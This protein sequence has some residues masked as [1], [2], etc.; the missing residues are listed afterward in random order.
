MITERE[1]LQMY[2]EY[3]DEVYGMVKVGP[4]EYETSGTFKSVDPIAYDEGFRN[5]IDSENLEV[6]GY[7]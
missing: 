3:L 7:T 4:Y 2:N 6:E 1:A 5:W